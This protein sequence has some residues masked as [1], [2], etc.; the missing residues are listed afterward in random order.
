M[1]AGAV[2]INI[3]NPT[4]GVKTSH[5]A[6]IMTYQLHFDPDI[7]LL[8]TDLGL[9]FTFIPLERLKFTLARLFCEGNDSIWG[10][11]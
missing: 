6:N 4:S 8:S 3:Q 2:V 7:H 11:D 5:P 9:I 10:Y 1:Y